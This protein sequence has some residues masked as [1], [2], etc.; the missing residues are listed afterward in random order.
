MMSENSIYR[1]MII[2][3]RFKVCDPLS[4]GNQ[5][6]VYK[7]K[8]LAKAGKERQRL[9]IKFSTHIED[10]DNEID[11]I[12]SISNRKLKQTAYGVPNILLEGQFLNMNE[13]R[14]RFY[15]TYRYTI[16]LHDYLEK[17]PDMDAQQ[18]L[19]ITIQLIEIM[20]VISNSNYTYN[21]LK[22]DNIMLCNS[23]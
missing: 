18:S 12:D 6:E 19:E 9:I 3:N 15:I 16:S 11:A 2:E 17:N 7:V 5:G 13:E 1:G 4:H 10:L 22:P 21:D 23:G 14:V 20:E 8:D